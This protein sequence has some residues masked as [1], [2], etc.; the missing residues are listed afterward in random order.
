[1]ELIFDMSFIYLIFSILLG[2]IGQI[3]LKFSVSDKFK[4]FLGYEILNY[5]FIAAGFLY[6]ISM[7]LYTHALKSIPLYIAFPSVSLS[8][9][10][11]A[12]L[13]KLIWGT[14]FGYKEI[15]ALL[16]IISGLVLLI[17]SQNN[18]VEHV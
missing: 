8:Y 13:S 18:V 16:L 7:L 6:F 10:L 3:L 12:W 14:P 9:V 17:S 15:I 11:V 4:S 2:V 1:M 5:P